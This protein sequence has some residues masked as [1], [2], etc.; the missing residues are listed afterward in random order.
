MFQNISQSIA[1][2][3]IHIGWIGLGVMGKPMAQHLLDA[4]Y[5]LRVYSR[6]PSKAKPLLDRG[7]SFGITAADVAKHCDVVFTMVGYPADVDEVYFGAKGIFKST[8]PQQILID[9]TTTQPFLAQRIA[10][11]AQR[12]G[13]VSLD[14]PVSGGDVGAREG[15]LSMMVGGDEDAFRNVGPLLS[16]FGTNMVYQGGAGAGQH[17]KMCNQIVIA[18]TM[19]GTCEAMMYGYKA[20]L[21]MHVVLQSIASGAAGCWTLNNLV[22][23]MLDRNFE[24]GFFVDHFIKDMQIALEES[25]RMGLKL[26]GLQLAHQLYEKTSQLGYGK[27]GTHALLLAL[28]QLA[29]NDRSQTI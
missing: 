17:A 27:K 11:Q 7:A 1:D 10:M 28:E 19:I 26:E 13:C 12:C 25:R 23:R 9:M 18:G 22:P 5:H 4:G 6:T 16:H 14:I 24:P 8:R 20:G 15:K 3:S 21:D 29:R 2:R